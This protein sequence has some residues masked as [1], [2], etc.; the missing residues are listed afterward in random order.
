MGNIAYISVIIIIIIIM[1]MS[2]VERMPSYGSGTEGLC[3]RYVFCGRC[4]SHWLPSV[5]CI[6]QSNSPLCA[7][8]FHG[9]LLQQPLFAACQRKQL[10]FGEAKMLQG[11]SARASICVCVC[12]CMG[13]CL[14]SHA[15][16][17]IVLRT[18]YVLKVAVVN[19]LILCIS[20]LY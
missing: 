7:R 13:A 11:S 19:A 6:I 10:I 14:C 1:I 3:V 5:L 15:K 4:S 9:I 17:T 12:V 8:L 20:L 16:N 18:V 2:M